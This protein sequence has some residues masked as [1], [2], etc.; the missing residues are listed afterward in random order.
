MASVNLTTSADIDVRAREIDWVSQFTRNYESY[1]DIMRVMRPI[2][3]APGTV[4]TQKIATVDLESG[5]VGEGNAIPRSKSKVIEKEYGTATIDKYSKETSIEAINDKGYAAAVQLTD[6]EFAYEL[7]RR[8]ETSFYNS[9]LNDATL[10]STEGTFQMALALALGRVIDRMKKLH[11]SS[12]AIIGY[13]NTLDLYE[14]Y[15]AANITVQSEN[16]VQYLKN[17]MGYETL[18]I[19]S[20]I[21]HGTVVA[22]PSGNIVNDYVDPSQSDFARAGLVYTTDGRTNLIGFHTEGEYNTAT[23]VAY[24]IMGIYLFPEYPDCVAV[25]TI[26][27]T[28]KNADLSAL[29]I[30]NLKLSPIFDSKVTKYEATTTNTTNTITATA[31]DS[32]ATVVIKV[33]GTTVTSG[34]VATWASGKNNVVITVTNDSTVKTYNITVTKE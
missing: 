21:P 10:R 18:I 1:T 29:S 7:F 28:A 9:L 24:A 26:D 22:T 8:V 3:R 23:S 2:K 5:T 6:D 4:L 31:A 17:F 14:Y 30:G 34:S 25:V 19:S 16:G 15:G 12:N 33:D 20:E 32:N 11:K 13:C 27:A